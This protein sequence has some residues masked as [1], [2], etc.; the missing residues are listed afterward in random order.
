MTE[1]TTGS[2]VPRRQLGRYLRDLRGQARL[3]VRAAAEAL[4]WSEAKIW[5]IETGQTSMR[6]LDVEQMCRIYDAPADLTEGLMALAKETKAKGWW[7]SYGG[8]VIPEGFDVYIGLEEAASRLLWYEAE[9][10]PG[11][12]QT[13]DYARTLIRADNP[14]VDDDEIERR[15]Q[16]RIARQSL[17]TRVTAAP[18]LRVVLNESILRRPVGGTAVIRAQLARLVEVSDLPNVA[19]KV[20]PFDIG[21]HAGIMS[22]P[23]VVLEFPVSGNGR[24]SEP[25][26]VYVDG[27][28][29]S[30]FLDKAGEIARYRTAFADIWTAAVDEAASRD[31]ILKTVEEF[32]Q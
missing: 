10:V 16:L 11:L 6:S 9:L 27:F 30:L 28:T 22:G 26:T 5:R 13:A 15:V 17:I 24:A 29:G 32:N 12:L 2:T 14:G 8:D 20:L 19:L 25:P 18:E 31:L 7:L 1:G 4:E 3:T 23:F 21:M